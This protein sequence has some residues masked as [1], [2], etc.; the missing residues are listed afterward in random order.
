MPP[1]HQD[2]VRLVPFNGCSD[3]KSFPAPV[4][5]VPMGP[6]PCPSPSGAG[7]EINCAT[8]LVYASPRADLAV[9]F[10]ERE[11]LGLRAADRFERPHNAQQFVSFDCVEKESKR[12][13]SNRVKCR[14]CV[15]EVHPF[16]SRAIRP[17]E[18]A[19]TCGQGGV[20]REAQTPGR[21]SPVPPCAGNSARRAGTRYTNAQVTPF[22]H[23]VSP[24]IA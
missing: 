10:G 7:N 15:I 4:K 1:I 8:V 9:L 24:W 16:I 5:S 6:I 2:V 11:V 13:P 21:G 22:C 20:R 17:P 18:P 14:R 12:S 3:P 23:G 19:R